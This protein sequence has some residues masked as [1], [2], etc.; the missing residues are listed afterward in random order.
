M[1]SFSPGKECAHTI[2]PGG[3]AGRAVGPGLGRSDE[4]IRTWLGSPGC[5]KVTPVR[6]QHSAP[7][8]LVW[9]WG[10]GSLC[11]LSLWAV[12]PLHCPPSSVGCGGF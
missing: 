11:V 4:L 12:V 10:T 6:G 3:R 7:L 5:R 1:G 2:P 8:I 9:G